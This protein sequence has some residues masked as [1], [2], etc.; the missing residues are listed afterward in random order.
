MFKCYN[1]S[2]PTLK[3]DCFRSHISFDSSAQIDAFFRAFDYSGERVFIFKIWRWSECLCVEQAVWS[4]FFIRGCH[5]FHRSSC[6]LTYRHR[7]SPILF[8]EK[9]G[10]SFSSESRYWHLFFLGL[11]RLVDMKNNIIRW[12]WYLHCAE[13]L[14]SMI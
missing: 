5:N 6:R 9:Q 12:E 1:C 4:D 8:L 2:H 10:S 14:F 11:L 3:I 7:R 13:I